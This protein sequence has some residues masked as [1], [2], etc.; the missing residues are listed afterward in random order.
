VLE[1]WLTKH[2]HDVET[3]RLLDLLNEEI[4]RDEV[5]IGPSY[6]MTDPENGPDLERIWKRAIMPLLEEYYYG[7]KWDSARFG[8]A[9]LKA[10]LRGESVAQAVSESEEEPEVQA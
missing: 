4:A 1:K 8:L 3:A 5:A 2:G 9:K 6:F 10:R 7:T